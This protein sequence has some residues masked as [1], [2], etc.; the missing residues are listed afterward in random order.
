MI[1][2]VF[3]RIK[4]EAAQECLGIICVALAWGHLNKVNGD[5]IVIQSHDRETRIMPNKTLIVR[6]L[7]AAWDFF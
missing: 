1:I 7:T 5:T 4:K 6:G 2:T 3:F